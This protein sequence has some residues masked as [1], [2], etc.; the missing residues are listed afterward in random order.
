MSQCLYCGNGHVKTDGKFAPTVEAT[1]KRK[2]R[3]DLEI[4]QALRA[5]GE[6]PTS[7]RKQQI[8]YRANRKAVV[9]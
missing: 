3:E 9:L 2:A 5:A 6:A 4:I 8:F 1:C 7:Y